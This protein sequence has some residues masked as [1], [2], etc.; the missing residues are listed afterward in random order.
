MTKSYIHNNIQYITFFMIMHHDLQ[1]RDINT[2]K[3]DIMNKNIII[4]DIL[5]FCLLIL[6]IPIAIKRIDWH[7]DSTYITQPFEIHKPNKTVIDKIKVAREKIDSIKK[8]EISPPL[9]SQLLQMKKELITLEK[10]LH[11]NSP[12][13]FLLGPIGTASIVLKEKD[14]EEKVI[15]ISNQLDNIALT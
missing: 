10:K 15:K 3:R 1:D 12:A 9:E 4:R 2:N 13:T 8:M 14:I 7:V 6:L 5:L 11:K